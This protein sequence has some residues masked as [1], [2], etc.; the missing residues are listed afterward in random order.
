MAR[1]DLITHDVAEEA[2]AAAAMLSALETLNPNAVED[3]EL[4]IDM[5]EGET[6]FLE[7]L[8]KAAAAIRDCE[9]I[10]D[11]VKSVVDGL[12]KRKARATATKN[13]IRSAIEQGLVL[14]GFRSKIVRPTETFSLSKR[15]PGLV[16]DD[17]SLIPARYF[18]PAAP[19]LDKVALK[20]A[21]E[22]SSEPIPGCHMNNGG[23]SLLLR[24]S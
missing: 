12:A 17:E 21:V 14:A 1:P 4:V 19:L 10:I 8:D 20:A 16:I 7:T 18:K 11:G 9:V 3:E 5:V 2:K 23:V 6:G 24:R 22:E 13:A 15:A